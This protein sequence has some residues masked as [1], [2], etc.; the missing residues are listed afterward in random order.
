MRIAVCF[1]GQIRTA[2]PASENLKRYFGELFDCCDFFI[3]TWDVNEQKAY[4]A[5]DIYPDKEYVTNNTIGK[6]TEIYNPI[7]F[8]VEN[9]SEARSKSTVNILNQHFLFN[10]IS[11]QWYSFMK[12][13]GFKK[14]YED[15][16]NFKYD[17]VLKLRMDLLFTENR[18]LSNEIELFS[19]Y[20]ENYIY[21]ENYSDHNNHIFID[22]VFYL[23]K[24]NTMN[25]VSTYYNEMESIGCQLSQ[26][27]YSLFDHLIKMD[28]K[29]CSIDN[30]TDFYNG[31]FTYT[32]YR[33]ECLPY[34]PMNQF[35]ECVECDRYHFDIFR[36]YDRKYYI[37]NLKEK[38]LLPDNVFSNHTKLYISQLKPIP[39]SN[40]FALETNNDTNSSITKFNKKL[41]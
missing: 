25:M 17:Y 7:V 38:Y 11:P 10:S 37:T 9:F 39:I 15:E 35:N 24:S 27:Q 33:P 3:H 18:R 29:I 26:I 32:I 28:V 4:N 34:S 20:S 36:G 5:S 40:L 12:C 13:V 21:I 41:I 22:D 1:I 14:K 6:I 8:E 30:W 23:S 2:I 16:N 31:V 19:E